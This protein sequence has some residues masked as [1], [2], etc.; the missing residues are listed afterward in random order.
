MQTDFLKNELEGFVQQT[1]DR[2]HVPGLALAIVNGNEVL[3]IAGYGQRDRT[4][5]LPVTPETLFPIASCTKSFTA[6]ALGLLVDEGKLD[7]DKPVREIIPEWQMHDPIAT[8]TLTVRD[9]LSHRC[10]LPSHDWLWLG[11]YFNRREVLARLRYLEPSAPLRSRFQYQNIMYMVASL[12]VNEITGMSWEHF[13]QERIFDGLGM[14]RSNFSTLVTQRDA[15]HARPHVYRDGQ[16]RESR[17]W[18][19]D[20]ENCVTGAAGS[21]CSCASELASWLSLQMNSGKLGE[22]QFIRP[23]TLET[24]HFPHI[25]IDDPDARKNFGYE[26]MSYGMGWFLR[27]HKGQVLVFHGGSV[28]GFGC[29]LYFMPRHRIG[30]AALTN[31]DEGY[32]PVPPIIA[33]TLFDRLL[34]LERGS[35]GS[36]TGPSDWSGIFAP[37]YAEPVREPE[38]KRDISPPTLA[39]EAYTGVY[40]HPGYG[41][42]SIR[43]AGKLVLMSLN[44]RWTFEMTHTDGDTFEAQES[45]WDNHLKIKFAVDGQEQIASLSIPLEE[46]VHDIVF[47]RQPESD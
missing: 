8:E 5:N 43:L 33:L 37:Y 35:P 16:I 7:W 30:I 13:V 27:S 12:L 22:R 1:M 41:R 45:E 11:S 44:D 32:N 36:S 39:I 31:C 40:E 23:E 15:N 28:D 29:G 34:G 6:M 14:K 20:G 47:I 9:M 25:F 3:H 10:G 18:E 46:A 17:F 2:W 42:V 26:F 19:Q 24:M 38:P 21:I 4:R